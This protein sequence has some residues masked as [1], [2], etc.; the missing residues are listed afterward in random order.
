MDIHPKQVECIVN[1]LKKNL[2]N[3]DEIVKEYDSELDIIP[4]PT[5]ND[6]E[7]AIGVDGSRMSVR[8]VGGVIYQISGVSIEGHPDGKIKKWSEFKIIND[9]RTTTSREKIRTQMEILEML[10]LLQLQ[11]RGRLPMVLI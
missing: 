1:T 10:L 8:C 3:V 2:S 9:F 4:L 7:N 11:E 6:K 5:P